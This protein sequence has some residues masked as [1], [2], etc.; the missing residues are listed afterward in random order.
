M[1]AP[2]FRKPGRFEPGVTFLSN[3]PVG[4]HYMQNHAKAVFAGGKRKNPGVKGKA[5]AGGFGRNLEDVGRILNTG[6]GD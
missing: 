3:F 1:D 4:I 6:I 5:A 2:P